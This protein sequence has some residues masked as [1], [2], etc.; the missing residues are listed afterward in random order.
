MKKLFT[1][2][3]LLVAIVT[4]AQAQTYVTL[5][6]VDFTEMTATTFVDGENSISD[7]GY[8]DLRFWKKSGYALTLNANAD[9]GVNFNKQNIAKNH[10]VAIPLSNVN[11]SIRVTLYHGYNSAKASFK[12]AYTLGTE[13]N[14]GN[15]GTGYNTNQQTPKDA[16]NADTQ[17]SCTYTEIGNS[18]IVLYI[19]EASSSY[20]CLKKVVIETLAPSA[21]TIT[22]QP[23]S[24]SYMTGQTINPLTVV[25]EGTG[26]L[27]YQWYSCDDANKTNAAEI[28]GATNASYTPTAAGFYYVTVT[29]DNGSVE[30]DVAQITIS[31]AEAPTI[32]VSGA[33]ADAVKVGTEVILTATATGTPTPTITWYDGN[34]TSVGTGDT[35][36]VPTDA[37]GTYTFYAVASNGVE[38]DATSATQTIIV[39]EQVATPTFSPNGAYFEESQEVTLACTDADATIQYSTDG[40]TTWTDYTA[41][42]TVTAT[43]TVQAKAVKDG[44]IDSE[45]A[46]ATFTKVEL[47]EQTDVTAAT[48]WDWSTVTNSSAVDFSNTALNNADVLYANIAAYGFTAVTGLGNE[49]ALLFNGQRAYNNANGSKHCQGNYLKFNTTIPGVVTVEYANT[50]GNPAR[51]V[52][53]NGQKG[54]DSSEANNSYK[55]ESFNVEAGEVLIKG[56]QVS[57]DADKMLRIRKVVFTPAITLDD[58]SNGNATK[59]AAVDGKTINVTVSRTLSPNY[60]NTIFLPFAMTAEQ[61]TAAFGEGVQVATFT[62]MNSETQFGFGN[63]TAMEANVPY[64]VKPTQ[65]VNG[66]TV[67]GVTISNTAAAGV[68][69]GGYSMVGNYDTFTNGGSTGGGSIGISIGGS[70][71]SSANE[72]YYF[73]TSNTIKKLSSTGS[74]KGLRAFMVKLP[75][76]KTSV[77][78]I[79][80]NAGIQFGGAGGGSARARQ[81]FVLNLD[82]DNTTTGI[83]AIENGQLTIDNDAPAYNLAGQKVG[84]GYKGIV[85][86]NG[87]KVVK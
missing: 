6:T 53:V 72:I 74:I 38:P 56:V 28:D 13:I 77:E 73:T 18:N 17:C 60:Y 64:L 41:A 83:E 36:T 22:T 80:S 14:A 63:V 76:G 11:G 51:T 1:L 59:I 3:T 44:C 87:K 55:S 43:T 27:T 81:D 9:E 78:T 54:T 39:K 62:G 71:S 65:E 47:V 57:D 46:T 61:V 45:V 30:S 24:A 16:A 25:A 21:P 52:N 23:Q 26:T 29:D 85:I 37:A 32:D 20:T 69:D 35:Y 48:T 79:V 33:P 12:T 5:R 42:F 82:D 31:A 50:G 49:T 84:K 75:A 34:D 2:L 7:A 4:G 40:G 58:T 19:G 86:I 15:S 10:L 67:E 66:F 8:T 70:S 68:V